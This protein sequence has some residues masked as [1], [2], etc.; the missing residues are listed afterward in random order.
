VTPQE[1]RHIAKAL[2][3]ELGKVDVV[4]IRRRMLGHLDVIDKNLGVKVADGLG[5][6]GDSI[7]AAPAVSPI[8]LEPSPALRLYGKYEPTLNGRKVGVLLA[9]GFDAKLKKA[10]VAAIE[11]EGAKA[12]IIAPKVGGVEDAGQTKHPADVALNGSPSVLFDAIVVLA[13]PDGDKALAANPDAVGFMMDACRHLKAMGL[14]GVPNLATRTQVS[15]VPGVSE[16]K[17][18]RDIAAFIQLARGGRV[19]ARPE[20]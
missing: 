16:L 8:D 20:D 19:W 12:A 6:A 14:A 11:K 10:V 13:G 17:S 1:Q 4:E 15:G 3:F 9:A 2:T 5:M 18:S 7:K